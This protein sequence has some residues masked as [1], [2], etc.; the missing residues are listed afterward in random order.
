MK[1]FVSTENDDFGTCGASFVINNQNSNFKYESVTGFQLS[2]ARKKFKIDHIDL[3]KMDCKGCEFFLTSEDLKD[4]DRVKIE[5]STRGKTNK[6]E[7]LLTLLKQ[8]DFHYMI[9]RHNESSRLSNLVAAAIFASK[10]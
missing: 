8:N 9:F 3:L 1:F 7:D 5:F 6:L 10:I 2:T 4:V